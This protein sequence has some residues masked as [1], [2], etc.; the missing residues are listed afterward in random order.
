MIPTLFELGPFKLHSYGLCLA[1]GLIFGHWLL[2]LE[3]RRKKQPEA[4]AGTVILLAAVFGIIGSR[5]F[6]TLEHPEAFSANPLK[7]LFSG[8]GLTWYGGFLM[9]TA[10]IWIAARIKK[11]PWWSLIDSCTPGLAIGYGFGRLGCFLSGDG[12]YGTPC[13]AGLPFPLCM[14]FPNG[15]VPTTEVVY[16]TPLW[17]IGGAILTFAFIWWARTRVSRPPLLFLQWIVIHAVL[18]LLVEFVRRNPELAFGL[19]QAQVISL[20]LIVVGVVGLLVLRGRPPVPAATAGTATTAAAGATT[21][22]DG[23][24]AARGPKGKGKGK[25]R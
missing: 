2:T 22:R 1:L 3:L 4:F 20:G 25:R 6:D 14:S 21:A 23:T 5:L 17:E 19:S 18:R 16:N 15:I 12:C 10:A 24:A 9:A 8:A 13:N 11:I 7:T